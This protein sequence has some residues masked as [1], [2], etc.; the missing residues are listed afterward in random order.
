MSDQSKIRNFSIIAH[1]DHGKSTLADRI[2][3]LTDT[4]ADRDMQDQL[5]DS[6]ELERERG[7]TIK[8]Q[9]VRVYF[10]ADDG[11]T[12]M[13]HLID[14]PG[15]VDFTYEVSRS[16]QACEGA[17]LVVD[18]SQGVEAQ[19]LANTYL[20]VE[21]GLEI[22]PC[23]NK[24][25]LP[26]A[27]PERVGAEVAELLGD[28]ADSILRIS[29]KTGEGVDAVLNR[30]V[31]TVP[32]PDGD[33]DAPARAL[34]FDSEF[35]QY[36]GVVAYIRVVDGVFK[37]GDKIRAMAAETEADV[38]ELGI[39]SPQM[40]P[41]TE[42]GPG[43]VGYVI[44]GIKDV[45]LLRVGDTLT[46]RSG[47]RG[48][49]EKLVPAEEALPGYREILPM[50]FCGLFPTDNAQYP[51]MRDALEKLS[52]NDAAL[53]WEP[54]TSDAL[55]FGFRIGF[56]GLLHMD[57]VRERLERE[58]DLDLIATMPSV[59]FEL[60]LQDGTIQEI[61]SPSAYPD[62][63]F[64]K[65]VS[66][67]FVKLNVL[68]PTEYVGTTM[69]LCQEKRG[70]H[71]GMQYI[72]ADRV[73]LTYDVPLV[74]IV[75]DFFDQLKSRTRGYASF[76]YEPIGLRESDLVKL[77]I[78]LSGEP[79]DA[80]SLL[81]HRTK[82]QEMGKKF[83][84]KLKEK[85]PRQQYDVP[86]Q[87][88]IGARVVSRETVKAYR[89]DVTEKLYGGDISRKKKLLQKQKVGKKRM[90]QVGNVEVPQEAFLAVLELGDA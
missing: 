22:I 85:I 77:D 84:E 27:E 44:T 76:D 90:K 52:L 12:Y 68:T 64:I 26:G 34:I 79:V 89:K 53:A 29:G 48:Q 46:H 9:A 28:D 43:E 19:T 33:R 54:E 67:P 72:S 5:L 20:A 37:K 80:L 60:E 49:G 75:L 88:A 81:V 78:L 66:E 14:T 7:I 39:F 70:E 13:F 10:D 73:Q 82:A 42:L 83:T 38:D 59:G 30:L 11:E 18:A 23:L 31:Q 58:Y 17:L 63:T 47:V 4:V 21:A 55:G 86:I 15:H 69:E 45:M 87:A 50:V 41:I 40:V 51:D 57:I 74:E 65:K 6:M 25:D 2:L 62:P 16:L 3:E 35:D 71:Q 56:L 32:A 24:I 1:I 8:S 36:R 61:H